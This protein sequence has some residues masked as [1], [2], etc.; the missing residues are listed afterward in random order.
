MRFRNR[1][2]DSQLPEIN[3]I[4]ML[5]VLM[6][7]LTFFI[8]VSMTLVSQQG[9][10]IQLPNSSDAAPP[11]AAPDPLV[12]K[13]TQQGQ[14]LLNEQPISRDQ[15]E[16]QMQAYLNGSPQGF[17]VLASDRRV[18]YSEVVALLGEMRE[19]GGDRVS[20]AIE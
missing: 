19:V 3:L 10:D 20:L 12:V 15:L 6:T 9:V 17:V 5:D 11:S 13:L 7:V 4:P 8:V 14:L 18:P 16:P 1:Q 2:Q